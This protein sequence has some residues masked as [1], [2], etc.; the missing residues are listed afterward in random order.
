MRRQTGPSPIRS[1]ISDLDVMLGGLL[2]GD[3]VVWVT[4]EQELFNHVETLLLS[5]TPHG[6]RALHVT[7]RDTAAQVRSRLGDRVEVIEARPGSNMSDPAALEQRIVSEVRNGATRV[8]VDGIAPFA[9]RWGLDRAVGFF[10]RVCPRLFDLGAIAYWRMSRSKLGNAAIDDIR[11]VTQC[12]FEV[13]PTQLRILKAEGHSALVQGRLFR[14][15][16][17]DDDI[18]LHAERALGRLA[19]G[20]RA[21]RTERSLSQADLARFADVTP[22]AISQAEAGQ[23]GLSLDTL[24]TLA[25][26]VGIGLDSLLDNEE[27]A[28]YTL[29]RRDRG[30][31][32]G[33]SR[34]LLDDPAAGLRVYLVNLGPGETGA[35][36]VKHKGAELVLVARGL[37]LVD[38]GDS[39]PA[40]RAGDAV[41]AARVPILSWRNLSPEASV[42]FWILRD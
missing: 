33:D 2:S 11:K 30:P 42:L 31:E 13:S 10:K 15:S 22:S 4:D 27:S 16:V 38:L 3:N 35:P 14:V 20:L 6:E 28:D 12:V 29:A 8:V 18:K 39:S 1:G 9:E 26:R 25:G 36:P 21:L 23:R 7:G 5:V 17:D 24:L 41:L 34:F 32:L 37:V 19:E 40:M